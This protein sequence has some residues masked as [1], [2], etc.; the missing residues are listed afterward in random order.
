MGRIEAAS[1]AVRCPANA[2]DL[3]EILC[4]L[5]GQPT[6]PAGP[7]RDL[8]TAMIERLDLLAT[9]Q[10][11]ATPRDL[12][13]AAE[14][15]NPAECLPPIPQPL[16]EVI[17]AIDVR[18][19]AMGAAELRTAAA[20]LGVRHSDITNA[21]RRV[22]HD[23]RKAVWEA[24]QAQEIEVIT[25]TWWDKREAENEQFATTAISA[26]HALGSNPGAAE[27]PMTA[28]RAA[29]WA[30]RTH[31]ARL[32][33]IMLRVSEWPYIPLAWLSPS[34]GYHREAED[35]RAPLAALAW[36]PVPG[37]P[38][39]LHVRILRDAVEADPVFFPT[40]PTPGQPQADAAARFHWM[41]G[42]SVGG[43]FAR[44]GSSS[45]ATLA[46]A[47][48]GS[49]AL[50]AHLL[51]DPAQVRQPVTGRLLVPRTGQLPVADARI[52][53][54]Q[55]VLIAAMNA[56]RSARGYPRE[57]AD[58]DMR[59]HVAPNGDLGSV[60]ALLMDHL[61]LP[62][63]DHDQ[64]INTALPD[65]DT[66]TAYLA[67]QAIVLTPLAARY[68]SG[69]G[70]AGPGPRALQDRH[71]AAMRLLLADPEAAERFGLELPALPDDVE[72]RHLIEIRWLEAWLCPPETDDDPLFP[73]TM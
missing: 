69:L 27:P 48:I 7:G 22:H 28:L 14:H 21:V 49:A 8:L 10:V 67:S 20:D 32:G 30:I 9:H 58:W 55:A 42:W 45:E 51:A 33:D 57:S 34:A 72:Y 50:I 62:L 40:G 52:V 65:E 11:L 16:V 56:H 4:Q 41:V 15:N 46:M 44:Y 24:G 2:P 5:A 23:Q 3:A 38:A 71:A 17:G 61:S 47:Q 39:P 63:P 12:Q 19:A 6:P 43:R 1:G 64:P 35:Y 66:F 31:L 18:T 68:L 54:L 26:L 73:D 29:R 59:P 37:A 36:Q 53:D 25:D 70:D 13:D 60:I